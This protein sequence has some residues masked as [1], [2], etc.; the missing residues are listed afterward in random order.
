MW[1]KRFVCLFQVLVFGP[2]ITRVLSADIF[3]EMGDSINLPCEY[4][5]PQTAYSRTT[6]DWRKESPDSFSLTLL[7]I[8]DFIVDGVVNRRYSAK[9]DGSLIIR[10]VTCEDTGSY[11]C[12]V[13]FRLNEPIDGICY[14]TEVNKV[15]L[16]V[17]SSIR[18]VSVYPKLEIGNGVATRKKGDST[19]VCR[20]ENSVRPAADALHWTFDNDKHTRHKITYFDEHRTDGKMDV[21]SVLTLKPPRHVPYWYNVSCSV[22]ED[23][24]S[25]LTSSLL[26]YLEPRQ[27]RRIKKVR[28]LGRLRRDKNKKRKN[29]KKLRK[30]KRRLL[31][32]HERR[33]E[34]QIVQSI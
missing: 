11:K 12:I 29:F 30:E 21:S 25:I 19:L 24:C 3:S 2:H 31:K 22:I 26:V 1:A 13:A 28:K 33:N 27:D 10:N 5:K 8:I 20:A 15:N 7:T 6:I 34:I 32:Q 14:H 23:T 4:K 16:T 9:E 17:K 18:G